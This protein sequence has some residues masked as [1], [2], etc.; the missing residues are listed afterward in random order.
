MITNN[1]QA[2]ISYTWMYAQDND[3]QIPEHIITSLNETA[4]NI[5]AENISLSK[6]HEL[7]MT[8]YLLVDDEDEDLT[9]F[10]GQLVVTFS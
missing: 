2:S 7:S 6:N 5:F 9:E 4:E 1:L 8:E 10:I 3:K